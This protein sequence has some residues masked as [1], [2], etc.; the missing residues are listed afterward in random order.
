ML[1]PILGGRL[2]SERRLIPRKADFA[3]HLTAWISTIRR[4]RLHRSICQI[5]DIGSLDEETTCLL[6]GLQY[7]YAVKG[8]TKKKIRPK[9]VV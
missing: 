6:I 9:A 1:I 4:S 8:V 5:I 3:I 7:N 2:K